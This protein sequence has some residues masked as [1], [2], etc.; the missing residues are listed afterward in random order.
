MMSSF[1]EE[2]KKLFQVQKKDG[3]NGSFM[4]NSVYS[5][6]RNMRLFKS[7]KYNQSRY[8]KIQQ[9]GNKMFLNINYLDPYEVI[10]CQETRT[11]CT[12][13]AF[14]DVCKNML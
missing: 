5:S 1:T 14:N 10:E 12:S 13:L 4:D 2:E 8:L 3:S 7:S 9:Y 6:H 11:R